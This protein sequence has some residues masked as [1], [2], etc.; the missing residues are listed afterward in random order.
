MRTITTNVYKIGE[1]TTPIKCYD[2]MR[3]NWHDLN[4][5]SVDEMIQS[6][7]ALSDLIGGTYNFSI[8]QV[9]DR[10]EHI[11]FYDYDH[12]ALKEIHDDYDLTG[13]WTDECVIRELKNGTPSK[14]LRD[15]HIDSESVYSDEGL[16][17]L[18]EANQYEFTEQGDFIS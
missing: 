17:E 13:V 11:S 2:W 3:D 7:I 18:C 4:Q 15:V 12:K 16:K 14:A 1:H 10:S 8:S 6:I 9:P 5:I